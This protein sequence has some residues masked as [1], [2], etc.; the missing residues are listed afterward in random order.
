ME[1]RRIVFRLAEYDKKLVPQVGRAFAKRNELFS[2]AQAPWLWDIIDKFSKNKKEEKKRSK[3]PGIILSVVLIILGIVLL[4]PGIMK[5]EELKLCLSAGIL[6][7]GM[8][9]LGLWSKLKKDPGEKTAEKLMAILNNHPGKEIIFH[10]DGV[11]I[12]E[13]EVSFKAVSKVFETDD[14]FLVILNRRF[15]LV[16][17]DHI[18]AGTADDVRDLIE[19]N[20]IELIRI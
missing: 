12:D 19:E 10:E 16:C 7:V 18:V 11:I 14:T 4:V 8:G 5:P 17:K 9:L 6:G 13:E 20:D 2:R 3:V 15:S 1:E